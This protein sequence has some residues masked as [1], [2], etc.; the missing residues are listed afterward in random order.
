MNDYYRVKN[1]SAT[2]SYSIS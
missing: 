2:W 1:N